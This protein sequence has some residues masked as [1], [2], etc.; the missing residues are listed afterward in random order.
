[1]ARAGLAA[2]LIAASTGAALAQNDAAQP[3]APASWWDSFKISGYAD[4]G[5]TGNPDDPNNGIN[6]GH[7]YTDRANLPVLN[8]ASLILSRPTDP[9]ATGYDWGFTLQGMYGTDARYTHFF[10]EFDR[11][12]NSR[13]QFDV[14]EADLLAHLPWLS[15]GG[16]DLKVGQFPRRS[17]TR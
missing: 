14:V 2:L 10:N 9:K 17:V 12:I 7:L 16:I 11:S 5:I 4:A 6:F 13:Y 3:R 1:M 8:Q 15:S